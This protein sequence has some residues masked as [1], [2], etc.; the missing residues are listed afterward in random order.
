ML[1]P[2][3]I[4]DIVEEA[5]ARLVA[6]ARHGVPEG[7]V[8]RRELSARL[9]SASAGEVIAVG[10]ALARRPDVK[11]ARARWIGWELIN[12]HKGAIAELDLP[13]VEAL[14]E[15]ADTWDEVDGHGICISGPAWRSG[16]IR[17]A[18]IL[19]WTESDDL[20][21]RRAA[22]VATVVLNSASHGG[23][24]DAARTLGV[25][26]RL[27]DDREDMVV[28][29]MSWALRKLADH[30]R[31]AVE[32]WLAAHGARVAA[33]VRREVGTKLRTGR[34]NQRPARFPTPA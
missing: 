31:A 26:D 19:A 10:L 33:R 1:S 29:A 24:G 25:A 27:V 32:A 8:I 15:G 4:D 28:K 9:R 16:R 18:D 20:W 11:A 7:R 30:D 2:S 12:K 5:A 23:A 22:L 17:D 13:H 6:R 3:E 14:L 34:K 21:R